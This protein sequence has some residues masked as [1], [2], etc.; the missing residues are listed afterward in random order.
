MFEKEI[1]KLGLTANEAKVYTILLKLGS[2]LAG[3]ITKNTGIHRRNVYD[4]IE[5]LMEKGLIS[6]VI[7]NNRKYFEAA[8]PSRLLTILD[9]KKEAI[10]RAKKELEP[11]VIKLNTI[12]ELQPKQEVRFF[13]GAEG[14]KTVYE[15]ILNTKKDYAGYGP[16]EQIE[17]VLRH[18]FNHFVKER[19]KSKISIKLIYNENSRGKKFTKNSFSE[20]RFLPEEFSSHA[21]LRIYG[22]KVAILLF[23]EE[24]PIA[25]VIENNSIADGYRKYFNVMWNSAKK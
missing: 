18:Y 1:G 25:I 20:I 16:G 17:K 14:F 12:K 3:D 13:K 2:S 24:E 23:S 6:F 8:N 21:A 9:E 22:N 15:D 11:I 4:S 5:R 7:I 10:N 19:I